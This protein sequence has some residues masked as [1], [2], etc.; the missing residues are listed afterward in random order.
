MA[1]SH[2][3]FAYLRV[4]SVNLSS[5]QPE[6]AP[7]LSLHVDQHARNN[8]GSITSVSLVTILI[9]LRFFKDK[10]KQLVETSPAARKRLADIEAFQEVKDDQRTLFQFLHPNN[11][12]FRSLTRKSTR[13]GP[14]DSTQSSHQPDTPPPSGTGTP[15]RR[16]GKKGKR[17]NPAMIRKVDNYKEIQE[18]INRLAEE[19]RAEEEAKEQQQGDAEKEGDGSTPS[20]GHSSATVADKE[21]SSFIDGDNN[22]NNNNAGSVAFVALLCSR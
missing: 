15:Q 12:I 14:H 22:T 11:L 7:C 5:R 9:R 6:N 4:S 17:L 3:A 20:Q 2:I 18:A 13:D 16:N 8:S 10:F 1:A 19:R 21:H